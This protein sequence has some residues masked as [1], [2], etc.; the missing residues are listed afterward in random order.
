MLD[1]LI[2]CELLIANAKVFIV[3]FLLY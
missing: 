2:R 3:C 1:W